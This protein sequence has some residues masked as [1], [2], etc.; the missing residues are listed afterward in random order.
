MTGLI[1]TIALFLISATL[2]IFLV[3]NLATTEAAFLTWSFSA[4]RAIV[5]A[6]LF[7]M[8]YIAGYILHALKPRRAAPGTA[9]V[10]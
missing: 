9:N 6:A 3:Q 10:A 7:L 5:F 8:G 4:P 2:A 1:R